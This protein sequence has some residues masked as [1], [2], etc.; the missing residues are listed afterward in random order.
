M[1][2]ILVIGSANVDL[3][4][5]TGRLP[6]PGETL[7][8]T[9]GQTLGGKGANQAVAA[10]RAGGAV[11]MIARV[12]TDDYGRLLRQGLIDEGV[13]VTG[14]KAMAGTSGVAAIITAAEQNNMIVV[15]SGA[16]ALLAPHEL[17]EADF[18]GAACVLL[19][20]E[21]PIETVERAIDLANAAG[22]RAILDPAPA[23]PL[24][25]SLLARIDWLTP[26]E[27]EARQLLGW[28]EEELDGIAAAH[29]LQQRGARGVVVKMGAR[30]AVVAPPGAAPV[31]LPARNVVAVDSTAA[32]DAFNG[33]F[34]VALAEGFTPI[35][36]GVFA[37]AA[38]SIAVSRKG[39]QL[40]MAKREEIDHVLAVEGAQR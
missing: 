30:G 8:G 25:A 38:S 9:F 7:F 1:S 39:A 32:G 37:I 10:A 27:S 33:A 36:A 23:M 22:A 15:S 5:A 40:A 20:L 6:V 3:V 12:G 31:A 28:G 18:A 4:M 29:A 11:A 19:Q 2:R 24:P 13:D 16:N 35:D 21:T 17:D 26:N 34:A 14:V